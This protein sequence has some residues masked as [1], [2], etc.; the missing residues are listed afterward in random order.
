M[1]VYAS[2]N[3]NANGEQTFLVTIKS[4]DN[5]LSQIKLK[6]NVANTKNY[7]LA[8]LKNSFGAILIG[9][10]VLLVLIGLVFAA[11]KYFQSGSEGMSDEVPDE[12]EGEA[13]Y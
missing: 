1:N 6:G 10:V 4:E 3:G 11:R 5:V 13:Y 2:S 8:A 12:A 9:I 7:F